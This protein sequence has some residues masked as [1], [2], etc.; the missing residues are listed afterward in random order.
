MILEEAVLLH[1]NFEKDLESEKKTIFNPS[2]GFLNAFKNRHGIRF[3]TVQG[4]KLSTDFSS[5]ESFFEK[6][7]KILNEGGYTPDQIY[8]CDETGLY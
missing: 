4:E 6:F 1:E 5:V 7:H 2:T 8:N 3:L